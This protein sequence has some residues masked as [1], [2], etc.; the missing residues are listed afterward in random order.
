VVGT[1]GARFGF[2]SGRFYA[3]PTVAFG[4]V[5]LGNTD[6][7]VYSFAADSG[8]L[9]WRTGTGG[10]V[11]AAGVVAQV[12]GAGPMVYVGSYDG[13]FY[14]ID[15][16]S[17][18]IRW[19]HHDGGHISGSAT[20]VGNTVYFGNIRLKQTTGLNARTGRRV[21]RFPDGAYGSVISDGRT[22]LVGNKTLYALQ[23]P[24]TARKLRREARRLA[25]QRRQYQ[26][27]KQQYQR[28]KAAYDA[29]RHRA[30][31]ARG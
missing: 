24:Q 19:S 31:A 4:R 15:A 6:G 10:Y 3:T 21:F 17:G 28:R 18:R 29:R 8:K 13:S 1:S 23:T 22:I 7:N 26:Q 30:A 27:R 12:P 9:A 11:Y 14:G 20:L 5:Y 2:G 16:R 25:R